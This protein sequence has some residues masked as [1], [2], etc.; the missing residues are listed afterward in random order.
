MNFKF[1]NFTYF[2]VLAFVYEFIAFFFPQQDRILVTFFYK[3]ILFLHDVLFVF[4]LFLIFFPVVQDASTKAKEIFGK[5]V[6]AC[7]GTLCTCLILLEWQLSSSFVLD[8]VMNIYIKTMVED[9]DKEVVA[10][11]CTSMADIIKDYGYVAVEPCKF[12][13]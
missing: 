12:W 11:A 10:Q 9:E 1:F 2:C 5:T 4:S 8:T 6:R 13:Y 7:Y 3:E